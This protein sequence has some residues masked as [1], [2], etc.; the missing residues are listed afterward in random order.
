M[1]EGLETMVR[2]VQGNLLQADAEA[3]VNTVNTV[4]VMGKGIALQFKKAFPENF[5]VYRR[6]C[7]EGK[8]HAG[9][10]LVVDT[11]DLHNPR[12]IINFPT[13]RHWRGSSKIEDIDA[14]L[15]DLVETVQ[16]LRIRSI[17]VPPLGCGNGGLKWEDVRPRI[18]AAFSGL[19]DTE[20]LV[21]EPAGAPAPADMVTR[22]ARPKMTA[23]RAAVIGLMSR[24]GIAGYRMTLLEVQKLVYF[25]Q[26]SGEPLALKF[27]KEKYGP[28]A[29]AL[30]HVLE[31]LEGHYI[32]GY[33]DGAN[34]P[35]T[36]ISLLP[37]AAED[38][39]R[40]LGDQAETNARF[41]RVTA[42][43]DGFETPYG[44]ELLATVHWVASR[45]DM[46]AQSDADAAVSGV[47][48]WSTRKKERFR[49]EHINAAWSR[50]HEQGWF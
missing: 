43:I 25:L 11:G 29:D 50:L 20:V 39:K 8:F 17:A 5:E 44:M 47:R 46:L 45:E 40:F 3:L 24:Y 15:V 18:V 32:V 22:T 16:K 33:G 13:K 48:N 30:R 21:Y 7:S 1:P 27:V 35:D 42:L 9:R 36:A 19:P 34:T 41:E 12:Y 10:M 38:A 31:R 37:D 49:P 28:Y 6:A 26:V 23:G 2:F 4:G 14:G